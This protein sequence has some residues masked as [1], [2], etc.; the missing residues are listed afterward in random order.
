M[1]NSIF[2][3]TVSLLLLAIASLAYLLLIAGHVPDKHALAI[4]F[5][6]VPLLFGCAGFFLFKGALPTKLLLMASLPL[7][8]VLYFGADSTKPGLENM[9]AVGEFFFICI[10]VLLGYLARKYLIN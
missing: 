8:H 1:I 6:L 10:G 7:I 5:M 3:N 2:I 9:I 4:N